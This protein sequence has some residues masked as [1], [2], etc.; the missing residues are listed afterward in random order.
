LDEAQEVL[1]QAESIEKKRLLLIDPD[2]VQPLLKSLEDILRTQVTGLYKQ[3]TEQLVYVI[4][5]R[6]TAVDPNRF[7]RSGEL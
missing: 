3:Y 4:N 1:Q 5:P 6:P 2:P 7:Y